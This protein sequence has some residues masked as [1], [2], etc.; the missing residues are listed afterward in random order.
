MSAILLMSG[1][2]C[3]HAAMNSNGP[4]RLRNSNRSH[5]ITA[6]KRLEDDDLGALM[7]L[8][9]SRRSHTTHIFIKKPPNEI[10][11]ALQRNQDLC[12]LDQYS[13]RYNMRPPASIL[14][15]WKPRLVELGLVPE[16]HFKE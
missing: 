13:Y 6:A 5:F 9:A 1:P 12:G 14:R 10:A 3:T 15:Q 16:S 8:S 4:S 7:C 2:A 11:E